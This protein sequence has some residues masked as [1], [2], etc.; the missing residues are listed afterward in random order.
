MAWIA[1][2]GVVSII[3]FC[4]VTPLFER[5]IEK[6]VG[7]VLGVGGLFL[8][9]GLALGHAG[10]IALADGST[11][12]RQAAQA[13]GSL[14]GLATALGLFLVAVAAIRFGSSRNSASAE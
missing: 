14:E 7:R 2:T 5:Q 8:C 6:A 10:G 3:L 4:L 11:G 1:L 9:L 12:A 13:L